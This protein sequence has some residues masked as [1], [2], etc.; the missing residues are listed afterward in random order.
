MGNEQSPEFVDSQLARGRATFSKSAALAD[1]ANAGAFQAAVARLRKKGGLASP[2]G[3]SSHPS[4]EDR[5]NWY[6]NPSRWIDP[7]M[8]HVELDHG[9]SLLRA[10]AFHALAHHAAMVF[11]VITPRQLPRIELG[12]QRVDFCT[13]LPPALP[14]RT[15]PVACTANDGGRLCQGRRRG[16]DVLDMCRYFHRAAEFLLVIPR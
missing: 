16:M 7:L 1:S 4:A 12:R 6:R 10:A 5:G 2:G 8:K 13:R 15:A 3:D 14:S 11:Q 9:V